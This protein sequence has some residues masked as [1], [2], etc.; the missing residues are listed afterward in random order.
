MA[1][2]PSV[3]RMPSGEGG[4]SQTEG[5]VPARS[6]GGPDGQTR[7]GR[8]PGEAGTGLQQREERA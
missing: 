1:L 3:P 2:R 5:D 8:V 4:L 6:N 7:G